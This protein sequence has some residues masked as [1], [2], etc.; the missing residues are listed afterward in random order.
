MKYEIIDLYNYF[1]IEKP[2]GA[3]GVLTAYCL[4]NNVEIGVKR[5]RSAMLILPGGGYEFVSFRENE[6]I[7]MAFLRRGISAFVLDYTVA[8]ASGYP[9][10]IRE[11]GMAMIYI[12]ENAKKYHIDPET[13]GAIGFSAGGHLCGCLGNLFNDENLLSLPNCDFV[14]PTAVILSYPVTVYAD[15]NEKMT[16]VG[17]FYNVSGGIKEI[18]EYLSLENHVT[19]NSS[20]AFL[21]HTYEDASVPLHGTLVLAQKYYECKVPFELHVYEKGGHGLSTATEEVNSVNVRV[22]AWINVAIDWLKERGFIVY[23]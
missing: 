13:V 15:A 22:S 12:R 8:P 17:S 5:P 2:E 11:A 9:T 23:S 1:K 10:Q 3:K 20:P 21:W 14:R 18:A 7:A 16:H 19:S 4:D 6:P